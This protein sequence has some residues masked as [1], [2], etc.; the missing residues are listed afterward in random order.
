[1]KRKV[2]SENELD[3]LNKRQAVIDEEK[4]QLIDQKCKLLLQQHEVED[5]IKELDAQRKQLSRNDVIS[6]ILFDSDLFH[7]EL[8]YKPSN[9]DHET[10]G[11][12]IDAEQYDCCP[13]M[14]YCYNGL[15]II[16]WMISSK[17][18]IHVDASLLPLFFNQDLSARGQT[19]DRMYNEIHQYTG[20]KLDQTEPSV[21]LRKAVLSMI[22]KKWDQLS[23]GLQ[24]RLGLARLELMFLEEENDFVRFVPPWVTSA[25]DLARLEFHGSTR[26]PFWINR[27][28]QLNWIKYMEYKLHLGVFECDSLIRD[29]FNCQQ[30]DVSEFLISRGHGTGLSI[31]WENV[32]TSGMLSTLISAAIDQE[33]MFS[34]FL[35]EGVYDPRLLICIYNFAFNDM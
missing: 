24:R 1:M 7:A 26:Y 19:K 27:I 10:I 21:A 35:Y 22:I 30:P 4:T 3:E 34:H 5:K 18:S 14:D 31:K 15:S 32:R 17:S 13:D 29:A 20:L 23:P 9:Y 8:K 2:E 25:N 16:E 28:F 12:I 33:S 6:S 11:A